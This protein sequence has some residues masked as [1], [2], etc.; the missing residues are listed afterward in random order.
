MR[1]LSIKAGP[2]ESLSPPGEPAVAELEVRLDAGGDLAVLFPPGDDAEAA[3]HQGRGTWPG[4]VADLVAG[5]EMTLA[6]N[7]T[8]RLR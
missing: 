7:N 8:G 5:V 3:V 4:W 2:G 6:R 1:E